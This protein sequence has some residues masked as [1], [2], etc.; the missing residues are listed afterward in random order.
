[1][2]TYRTNPLDPDTDH[3][4]LKDG[5]EVMTY[6]TNPLNPDTDGDGL[7]DGAEV[8]DHKTDPLNPDSDFD[9]LSDGY[10]VRVSKTNP[11]DPDTDKGGVRDG[12]E[13]I[14]DHTDPL[15]P[16]DDILFFELNINFDTDKDVIKPEFFEQLDRTLSENPV[17]GSE[18]GYPYLHAIFSFLG[19]NRDFCRIMLGPHGDMQFVDRVKQRVDAQCSFIWQLLAPE[20]ERARYAM[21]NAFIIN[22]CIGL[23]QKWLDDNDST[24]PEEMARLAAAIILASVNSCIS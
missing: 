10:E 16:S 22:G 19:E 7:L 1:M 4:G 13:V 12:H 5:E 2:K 14:Y 8:K 23:I 21:Y 17:R 20:T 11:L 24:G 18:D 15:D 3:D 9:M 6:K